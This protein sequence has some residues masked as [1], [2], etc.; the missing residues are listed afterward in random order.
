MCTFPNAS[1]R[2][3]LFVITQ[4]S[5]SNIVVPC[6]SLTLPAI[7]VT[8]VTESI[9]RYSNFLE[10]GRISIVRTVSAGVNVFV[11]GNSWQKMIRGL[12]NSDKMNKNRKNFVGIIFDCLAEWNPF[13]QAKLMGLFY[14]F[15]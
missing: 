14:L 11:V 15:C 5:H 6:F 12:V 2:L 4:L 7:I 10:P 3:I 1:K 8:S 13:W 9:L